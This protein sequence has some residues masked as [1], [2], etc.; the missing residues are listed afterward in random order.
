MWRLWLNLLVAAVV[1]LATEPC[2]AADALIRLE[3]EGR[4]LEGKVIQI[5]GDRVEFLQRDGSLTSFQS[6]TAKHFSKIGD[7]FRP[8]SA[9]EMRASLQAE[10]GRS[11]Q[12]TQTR[13]MLVVHPAGRDSRWGERF[14]E[15]HQSFERYFAVRGLRV[16]EPESPLVA[17]VFAT[18]SQMEGYAVRTLD[19][20]RSDVKGYYSPRT[21]RIVMYDLESEQTWLTNEDVI[22]HEATHQ[23]AFNAGIHS[24]F[25]PPPLWAAEGLGAMFE[26][27]AVWKEADRGKVASRINRSRLQGYRQ[28]L[29]IRPSDSLA[30][31]IEN[32]HLFKTNAAAAYAQ[33]WAL[34]FY[35]AENVPRKYAQY[36]VRTA[37][38]DDFHKVTSAERRRDFVDH[39]GDNWPVIDAK[40]QRFY[41]QFQ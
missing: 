10:F 34:T 40:M 24:R 2:A 16:R 14:E 29:K 37:S 22:V 12:V 28:W 13:S 35:L 1:L 20:V 21:N 11:Y 9:N 32:D 41:A 4:L 3:S 27:S 30:Q 25:S 38:Y 26:T 8:F 15:I 18:R 36:L 5:E 33:A 39:F 7:Q 31:M 19:P 23:T 17:V 6:D